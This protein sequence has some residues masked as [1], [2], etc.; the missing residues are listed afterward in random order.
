M[1]NHHKRETVDHTIREA[2]LRMT[3]HPPASPTGFIG[4]HPA[5]PNGG[6]E[7]GP[8]KRVSTGDGP[9]DNAGGE[10]GSASE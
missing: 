9:T 4:F 8:E 2:E 1:P 3:G 5:A 10:A 6:P 7:T